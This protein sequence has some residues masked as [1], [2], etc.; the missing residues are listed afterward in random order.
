MHLNFSKHQK[1][2]NKNPFFMLD[3]ESLNILSILK[4]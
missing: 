3:V 2:P 1:L 4:M